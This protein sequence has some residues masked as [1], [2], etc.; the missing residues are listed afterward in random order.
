MYCFSKGVVLMMWFSTNHHHTC[1]P[2]SYIIRVAWARG[3]LR[4]TVE[5]AP[6]PKY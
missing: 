5:V 6:E 2:A 1:N 4:A 3:A